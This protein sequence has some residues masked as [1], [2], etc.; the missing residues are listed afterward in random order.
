MLNLFHPKEPR[1]V[2]LGHR[3]MQRRSGIRYKE[4][5]KDDEAMYIPLLQSLEQ[6]LNKD[7]ILQ[8]VS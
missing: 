3:T 5:L 8:E 1:R 7:S 6:L 4:V 2:R